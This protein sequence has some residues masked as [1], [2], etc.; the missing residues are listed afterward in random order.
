MRFQN[1][2]NKHLAVANLAGSGRFDDGLNGLL[3]QTV[4][5][6]DFNF[7]FW[8][9]TTVYLLPRY[10]SVWPFWRPNPFTSVTVMPSTPSPVNASL[11]SSSLNGLMMASTFF[12]IQRVGLQVLTNG[13]QTAIGIQNG[14]Q[15]AHCSVDLGRPGPGFRYADMKFKG[16]RIQFIRYREKVRQRCIGQRMRRAGIG[17]RFQDAAREKSLGGL[18]RR[19]CQRPVQNGAFSFHQKA[20]GMILRLQ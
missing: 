8:Q 5:R 7:D 11:T 10:N 14:F 13:Q 4:R 18:N 19:L 6:H 2:G 9:K 20:A 3:H 16:R 15:G 1:C 12:M 17:F